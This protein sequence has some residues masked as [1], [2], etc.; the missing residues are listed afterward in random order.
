MRPT[1]H[2]AGIRI[3]PDV[4]VTDVARLIDTLCVV[5]RAAA[6]HRSHSHRAGNDHDAAAPMAV[7]PSRPL[8]PAPAAAKRLSAEGV[9]A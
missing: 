2:A 8:R 5:V 4:R 1:L 7:R 9:D 3:A 6:D